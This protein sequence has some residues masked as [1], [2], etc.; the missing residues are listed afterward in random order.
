MALELHLDIEADSK[1]F[2]GTWATETTSKE[3]TA[4]NHLAF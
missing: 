3:L 2:N 1:E 4:L